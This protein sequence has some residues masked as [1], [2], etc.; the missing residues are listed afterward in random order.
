MRRFR[1]AP[2]SA[3]VLAAMAAG[4]LATAT[5]ASA[6]KAKKPAAITVLVTND[7][8]Y[9]AAGIDTLVETLRKVKNT[10]VVVVAPA[11]NQTGK[12]GSTSP[13]PLATSAATTASGYDAIAVQGTPADT[14]TAALDQLSVK[15]D[16]VM[17]GINIGQNM[18]TLV[19]VS[20]TVGAARMAARRGIP[21]VALSQGFGDVPQFGSA[22]KLAVAWLA[23]HR[24]A[25][26]KK[27]TTA[28]TAVVNINVPNCPSGKPRGVKQVETATTNENAI[29]D[30]DCTATLTKPA[31]DI[32][33]FNAGWAVEAPVSIEPTTPAS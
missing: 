12:G 10:K 19:D 33:G 21:A 14:V 6:A 11:T 30:V 7:D 22:A 3:L 27:P 5:P 31:T 25:L 18:G 29:A 23:S 20:G 13:T 2:L 16:V 1:S 17:S 4:S 9:N 15:P 24:S 32:E 26:A 8:G 28:P